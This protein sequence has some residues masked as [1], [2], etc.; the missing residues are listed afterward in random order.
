MAKPTI[1]ELLAAKG[2][3]KLTMTNALDYNT[4]R[5]A[6]EA[7]IDIIYGRGMYNEVQIGLV[8]DQ[9][10]QAAPD[11]IIACNLPPTIAF[12]SDSEAIRCAMIARDHGADLIFSSGNTISRFEA[13]ASV[14]LNI[15]GHVGL[16]PFR[17]SRGGGLRATGKTLD[18]ALQ[19]YRDTLAYEQLGAMAVEIECVA[20]DIAAEITKRVDLLTLSLGS[21][22]GCDGQF[23][24]S[25]DMLGIQEPRYPGLFRPYEGPMPRH[26][27]RYA[28]LFEAAKAAF[29]TFRQEV[30]SGEFPAAAHSIRTEASLVESFRATID[31]HA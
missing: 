11:A 4:A 30:T 16:V 20:A 13:M 22:P 26:A 2:T 28:N 25:A 3:R 29:S 8:L 23:L 31:G 12:V 10:T 15:A 27:K 21:G 7:G 5:A 9:I 1:K 17:A 14:G 6:A 18:E 19:I 24:F